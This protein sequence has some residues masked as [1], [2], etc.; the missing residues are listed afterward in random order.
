MFNRKNKPQEI[1]VSVETILK[2][3]AITALSFLAF[4]FLKNMLHY[5]NL[6]FVSFFLALALNPIVTKL[7]SNLRIKSRTGATAIAYTVVIAALITFFSLVLP[8]LIQQTADFIK[9]LPKTVQD[10]QSA[11]N[12]LGRFVR[13]N[14]IDKQ[15]TSFMSSWSSDA[16]RLS[17]SAVSI[18]NRVVSNI[19]SIVTVLILTFMMLAEGP[20]WIDVFW[21][22]YPDKENRKHHKKLAGKMYAVVINYVNGQVAVAAIGAAF[23]VVALF[24]GTNVFSVS[25]LNIIALGGLVFI[26]SLIPTIGTFMGTGVVVL[27]SALVSWPLALA[28]LIYFIVY[29]QIENATIQPIIQSRGNDLTPMLVFIAAILGIGFGGV[30]G[31]FIAIPVAG[32][33]RVLVDDW[34]ENRLSA[35]KAKA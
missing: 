35:P 2:I 31:A 18:V 9:D 32:C 16:S 6:I 22:Y 30:L 26:F 1:T 29:Q 12:T 5:L 25:G 28:M 33:V 20:R 15:I 27:F 10:I 23:A 11:D 21:K 24:I 7:S 34:L 4:Q 17:S 19:I 3:I 8:P 14:Q 13:E